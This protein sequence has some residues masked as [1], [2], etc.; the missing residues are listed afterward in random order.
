[1]YTYMFNVFLACPFLLHVAS[2]HTQC[3]CE[4]RMVLRSVTDQA[5]QA[6]LQGKTHNKPMHPS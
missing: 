4:C 2:K 3:D 6:H 5:I 1:M